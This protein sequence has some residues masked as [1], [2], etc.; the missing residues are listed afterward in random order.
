MKT[1]MNM[2]ISKEEQLSAYMDDEL[3]ADSADK[4]V[5][6]LHED[7]ALKEK[8]AR[9]HLVRDIVKRE[10]AAD[11]AH[12]L[13]ER[14]SLA[15]DNEPVILAPGRLDRKPVSAFARQVAGLAVAASITAITILTIQEVNKEIQPAANQVAVAKSGNT[16]IRAAG[17]HWNVD[18]PSIESQ[19]NAYIVKHNEYATSASM[20]G[21]MPYAR[22]AGY[23]TD[24]S[25]QTQE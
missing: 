6:Q 21:M 5:K 1:V 3:G 13:A 22:I 23:D 15:I 7:D 8:W 25:A 16:W 14:V 18:E 4:L 20:R 12:N 17:T 19:L 10:T 2:N 11:L 9:Y 24:R